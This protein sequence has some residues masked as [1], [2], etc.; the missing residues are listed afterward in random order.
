MK[1]SSFRNIL[2]KNNLFYKLETSLQ[3]NYFPDEITIQQLNNLNLMEM[4]NIMIFKDC[5]LKK[6]NLLA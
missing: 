6:C 3:F 5:N 4:E 2:T 1:L